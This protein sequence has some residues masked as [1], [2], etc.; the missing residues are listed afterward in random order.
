MDESRLKTGKRIFFCLSS[1]DRQAVVESI[2]YHMSNF[3]F[4]IWYDRHKMLMGDKRNYKNFIEGILQT[5]YAIIV[6]S[7]N[8]IQ[9]SCVA[10]EMEHLKKQYDKNIITIFPIF[11]NISPEELPEKY[12]WLTELVYKELNGHSGT[13]LTCNHIITKILSD[14]LK[15][16][17][18]PTLNELLYYL[19]SHSK[20]KFIINMLSSY[21]EISG[22]NHNAR[23]SILYSMC[24]YLST[25]TRN[26]NMFPQYYWKGFERIFSYTKLNLAAD[27]RETLILEIQTMILLNKLY[28]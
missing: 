19:E 23:I 14:E 1:K 7:K 8:S 2:V 16:C 24:I 10:E 25:T 17:T 11:Y 28:C 18:Y 4:A 5:E 26:I 12:Q 21:L 27:L 15:K 13:L 20:D 6:M 9:S 3:G 22:E